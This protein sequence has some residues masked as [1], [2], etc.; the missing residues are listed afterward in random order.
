[1]SYRDNNQN[2][3]GRPKIKNPDCQG[4]VYMSP[5]E[6][7][8]P[9]TNQDDLGEEFNEEIPEEMSEKEE[10]EGEEEEDDDEFSE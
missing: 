7:S 6:L 1:M 4:L 2:K 8:I 3:K 5:K 10:L 9:F